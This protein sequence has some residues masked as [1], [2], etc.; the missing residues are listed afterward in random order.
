MRWRLQRIARFIVDYLGPE[1]EAKTAGR[2]VH[3]R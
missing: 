3:W 2:G 1:I